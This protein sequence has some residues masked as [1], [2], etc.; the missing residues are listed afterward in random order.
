MRILHLTLK[1]QW[2]DLIASGV[3][4]EEYREMKPYWHVRLQNKT[5]DA[6]QFR[7]GYGKH[8]PAMLIELK[9]ILCG[10]G[11]AEWGAPTEESV[12]ILRLGQ[13]L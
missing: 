7:N 12:Y 11:V 9:E 8:A 5:Y 3:K 10:I 4:R 1:K 6:I 13:I 2:F